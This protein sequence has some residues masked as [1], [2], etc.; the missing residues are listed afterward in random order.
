MGRKGVRQWGGR[1]AMEKRVDS[2][3]E[4]SGVGGTELDE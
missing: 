4:M 1:F 3:P 2:S